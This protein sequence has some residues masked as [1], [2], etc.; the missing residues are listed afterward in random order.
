LFQ[1]FAAI[2]KAPVSPARTK[3]EGLQLA[4]RIKR[5][6]FFDSLEG[7]PIET[8]DALLAIKAH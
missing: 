7:N 5:V 8:A 1:D 4:K 3:K 6:Q 2:R